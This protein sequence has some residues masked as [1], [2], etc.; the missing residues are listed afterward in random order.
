MLVCLASERDDTLSGRMISG[1][2]TRKADRES[3]IFYLFRSSESSENALNSGIPVYNI[4]A[5]K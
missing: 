4:F 5:H 1:Q 2:M 3:E